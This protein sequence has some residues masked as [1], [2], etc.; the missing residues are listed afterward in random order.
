M[1]SATRTLLAAALVLGVV[2]G[3]AA[4]PATASS[5]SSSSSSPSSSV[6]D[7]VSA[8]TQTQTQT[9]SQTR[10]DPELATAM[11]TAIAG[12]PSS[13]ATAALVRVGG[14]DGRWQGSS[15]VHDLATG[16][17]ADPDAR[18]RAGSVTKVF[19]AAVVLQ[20]ASEGKV[21]LDRSARSYLPELI[22]ASYGGVTVRQL[23]NHT[24]GIPAAD[25]SGTTVEEW[26]AN[27]FRIH[28]PKEMVRSATAKEREFAPGERQH[29]LNIGYT[30]AGLLVERVTGDSYE[31]QVARRVLKPL[32]LRDT[33]FPG[34]DPRIVGPHNHG[35][36]RMTLDDGTT[37]LRDVTVWGVT[38]GWAA[39]DI[40]STTADL[41]R[42][43]NALFRGRIVPRGPVL[44]EMF[45]VPKVVDFTSGKPAEFAAGLARKVLGGR[46]VWGKTGGRWGYNSAIASTRDGSRT[47][48]Y[49]VN[50]TDAKGRDV[51]RV[52]LN[53]MVAAYGTPS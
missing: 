48:V 33:Y 21:D 34:T 28:D 46:E 20:L 17:A 49:S 12:L 50:S 37:G 30:I 24:H 45:T 13:D 41:E 4:L 26:Y 18:F 6:T 8:Q 43:T 9:Q 51:N 47:V 3:P 16:R 23:L 35:Y 29:Y 42:F 44:E 7:T 14:I 52:A 2:T 19:T 32:G 15:G 53:V 39:G 11:E 22:P 5:S 27:R 38:D 25:S 40:V 10:T 1:K 31:R 36:Q